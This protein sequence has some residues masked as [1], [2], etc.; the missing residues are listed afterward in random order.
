[1]VA[2]RENGK[3]AKGLWTLRSKLVYRRIYMSR[4]PEPSRNRPEETQPCG[5]STSTCKRAARS[6][7]NR[8]HQVALIKPT[9]NMSRRCVRSLSRK[10]V[11]FMRT[12]A[13]KFKTR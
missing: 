11:S 1:R 13:G 8:L 5:V 3:A 9:S 7:G 10:E 6:G 12:K 4:E 2:R